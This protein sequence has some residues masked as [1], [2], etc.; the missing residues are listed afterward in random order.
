QYEFSLNDC[1]QDSFNRLLPK[2]LDKQ[3]DKL[4]YWDLLRYLLHGNLNA[5]IK[6]FTV[7]L[8]SNPYFFYEK[9]NVSNS[10]NNFNNSNVSNNIQFKTN[11]LSNKDEYLEISFKDIYFQHRNGTINISTQNL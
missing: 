11:T 8:L 10:K 9:N 2:L 7:K 3:A 1:V 4:N 6:S 5:H